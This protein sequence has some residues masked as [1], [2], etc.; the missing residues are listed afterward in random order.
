ML[1]WYHLVMISA[2]AGAAVLAWNVPR[3]VVWIVAGAISYVTS[4]WWHNAGLPGAAYYGAATNL[5]ICYL[6]WI[7]AVRRYEMRVWNCFHLMIILDLLYLS[8]F[9]T[10][11]MLFAVSLEVVNLVALSIIALTGILER[12]HGTA[13]NS[14]DPGWRGVVYRGLWKERSLASRPWWQRAD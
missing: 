14:R 3:A 4:A 6:L 12:A 1:E 5:V 8:G 13:W 2:A 9:I 7:F 11:H 10:D